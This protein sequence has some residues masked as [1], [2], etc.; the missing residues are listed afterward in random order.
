MLPASP[1]I[2]LRL[3]T[4]I[5]RLPVTPAE[6]RWLGGL[7]VLLAALLAYEAWRVGVTADEPSHL[8]SATLYWEGRDRLKPQDMPPLIKI[9]GGWV[10]RWLGLPLSA[11]HPSWKTEHEWNI[12]TAMMEAFPPPRI[13]SFFF[14]SRLPMLFFPLA[15]AVLLWWWGRQLGG[16]AAALLT[17]AIFATEPTALGHGAL[18][19]NDLAATF[20]YLGFWYAAW[21][22]WRLP[23]TA[24]AWWLAVALLAACLT[25]FSMLILIPAGCGVILA[26]AV[27]RPR[28]PAWR[29]A[30]HLLL[31]FSVLYASIGLAFPGPVE[32]AH[33]AEVEQLRGY[34]GTPAVVRAALPLAR[35]LPAPRGFW[36]GFRSLVF[37]NAAPVPVYLLGKVWPA[38]HPLYFLVALAVKVPLTLLVLLLASAIV[39]FRRLPAGTTAFLVLPPVLYLVAASAS[40]LQLGVRLV[41]P[42][43]PFALLL[44]GCGIQEMLR[45]GRAAALAI[46]CVLWLA[47][48]LPS[49]PYGISFTN[50]GTG[51]THRALAYVGDSNLD[52][53]HGLPAL[54]RFTRE[55]G[56]SR[57]R[58]AYFG[59]DQPNRYFGPGQY[60]FLIPPWGPEWAKDTRLRPEPGVYY[61]VSATLLTGAHFAPEY[62]DYYAA[63]RSLRPVAQPGGG[64]LVYRLP[65]SGR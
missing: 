14:W 49:F 19:K 7:L 9:V 57:I 4:H 39:L 6:V 64:I 27:L 26:R 34:T 22:Y 48:T 38:G 36:E 29:A 50:W 11:S 41:L 16:P 20:G 51:G 10:P 18:F 17:A 23:D 53:G 43:L 28:S 21:R 47:E 42:A 15:T 55:R 30:A 1:S 3:A 35:W 46:G 61:A 58:L 31:A 62:R 45:R 59:M 32:K 37:S 2:P 54:A 25:K 44:A 65:K 5:P 60:E 40:S 24:R 12:S 13:Q 33:P 63:F 52:W 8:L 56:I